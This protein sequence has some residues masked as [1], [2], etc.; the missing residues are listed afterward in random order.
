MGEEVVNYVKLAVGVPVTMRFDRHG[1]L[2]KR[3]TDP[4]LG[5]T[6]TVRSLEFHVMELEGAPS[7]TIFSLISTK[8]QEE[9]APYLVG[10]KYL[11]YRFT[12]IKEEPGFV[13]PRIMLA[14]PL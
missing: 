4:I 3:I 11:R 7:D 12:V 1:W 6:K 5:F 9:F 14:T 8:A 10:E 2:E 13:A